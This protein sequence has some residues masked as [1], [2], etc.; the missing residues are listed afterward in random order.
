MLL[1]QLDMLVYTRPDG[2]IIIGGGVPESWL[3]SPL[4]VGPLPTIYGLVEWQWDGEVLT[5]IV[6][7]TGRQV[8]PGPA[9]SGRLVELEGG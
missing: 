2:S 4:H 5:V 6:E 7:E 1:L 3:D 9:F 8:V